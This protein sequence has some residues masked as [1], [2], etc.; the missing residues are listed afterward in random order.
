MIPDQ[1]VEAAVAFI[2]DK[3][4][5]YAKAKAERIQ[6]EEFR[7]SQKALG[8]R[9][10]EINGYRTA[11]LQERE[12]YASSEYI[13]LLDGLKNAV[14]EEEKLRWEMVA[15][16]LTVEIYRTQSANSRTIDRVA[17]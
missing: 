17:S 5:I 3:A 6:L 9:E 7:K 2:R 16:Q 12:A 13:A 10:A 4:S 1:R 11:A 8:M 14:E 15:A